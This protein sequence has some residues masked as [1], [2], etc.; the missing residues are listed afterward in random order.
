MHANDGN[1][2]KWKSVSSF[3]TALVSTSLPWI[4]KLF[5]A[6]QPLYFFPVTSDDFGTAADTIQH[7]CLKLRL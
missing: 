2:E 7:L 5:L 3:K 6:V 1:V 4:A